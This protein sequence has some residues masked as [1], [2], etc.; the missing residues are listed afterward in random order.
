MTIERQL[1]KNIHIAILELQHGEC[2]REYAKDIDA[3]KG[4][5]I[6][7]EILESDF[8]VN[9]KHFLIDL[10]IHNKISTI[11]IDSLLYE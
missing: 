5:A 6:I 4:A 11:E 8:D 7:D 3:N 9:T 2:P 10:F 1:I